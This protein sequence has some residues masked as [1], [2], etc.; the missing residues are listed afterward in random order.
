MRMV[1]Q[2]T[3]KGTIVKN[4]MA[5][6]MGSYLVNACVWPDGQ[7]CTE[8]ENSIRI[9]LGATEADGA[10]N[11]LGEIATGSDF[12]ATRSPLGRG[13]GELIIHHN[14]SS[15]VNTKPDGLDNCRCTF[16]YPIFPEYFCFQPCGS[17]KANKLGTIDLSD[18]RFNTCDCTPLAAN[19]EVK[20]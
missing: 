13:Y 9:G 11:F 18:E 7:I 4:Q 3:C 12:T 2:L 14:C 15:T 5:E 10:L 1:A 6:V 20:K 8:A 17:G 19:N 16:K